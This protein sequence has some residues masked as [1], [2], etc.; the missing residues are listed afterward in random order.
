MRKAIVIGASSGI[1]KA[2]SIV[3]SGKGFS[4][5]LAG[6]NKEGMEDAKRSCGADAVIKI[7]DATKYEE[8]A[9]SFR[10][11]IETMGGCDL[12]VLNAGVS[13]GNEE[14]DW[15]KDKAIIDLNVLGFVRLAEEAFKY[16]LSKGEG[17]IVGISSVAALQGHWHSPA[18]GASKAFISKYMEGLRGLAHQNRARITI[19]DIKPG[20]VETPMTANNKKMFWV[21]SVQEAALE[22]YA[23]IAHKKDH[24]YITKRWRLIAWLIKLTP[25]FILKRI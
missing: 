14:L 23:A 2:L 20:F 12:V 5:G 22:I 11:L 10:E 4:M 17:H 25:W 18:Y 13:F 6:R 24:A 1:G 16:F 21:A 3:L 15:G 7:L 8:S 9:R 19:T